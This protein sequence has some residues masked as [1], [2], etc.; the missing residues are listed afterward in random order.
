MCNNQG[1][2]E[3]QGQKLFIRS[4]CLAVDVATLFGNHWVQFRGRIDD[5]GRVY[6]RIPFSPGGGVRGGRFSRVF[7]FFFSATKTRL[8]RKEKTRFEFN[9]CGTSVPTRA[10]DEA[11]NNGLAIRVT[12]VCD[13]C[14]DVVLKGR[15]IGAHGVRARTGPWGTEDPLHRIGVFCALLFITDT[16]CAGDGGQVVGV[17]R[18]FGRRTDGRTRAPRRRRLVGSWTS[19]RGRPTVTAPAAISGRT[20]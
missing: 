7:V 16:L 8:P 10:C 11:V 1:A 15:R 13:H 5:N 18:V 20:R 4:H 6:A 3:Q 2:R 9:A 17:P 19:A 14:H 12:D